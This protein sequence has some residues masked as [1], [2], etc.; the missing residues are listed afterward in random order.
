M[1]SKDISLFVVVSWAVT[2]LQ[3]SN[4]KGVRGTNVSLTQ[5][6]NFCYRLPQKVSCTVASQAR[7]E[8]ILLFLQA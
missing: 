3:I 4:R 5:G 8:Q 7:R 1:E 2:L 6:D